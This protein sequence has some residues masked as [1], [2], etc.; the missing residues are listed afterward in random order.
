MN[1]ENKN[2]PFENQNWD[3]ETPA[4][5]HEKRFLNKLKVKKSKKQTFWKPLAIACSLVIGLGVL[6][7]IYSNSIINKSTTEVA[8]SPEVQETN[9][10]FSSIINSELATLKQKETPQSKALISDALKQMESLEKDYE[11]LKLEIKKP[12]PVFLLRFSRF[13]GTFF[14]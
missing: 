4:M 10:Y 9:D 1:I 5:G 13:F 7:F 8:F 12:K 6:Y 11:N 2:N 14:Y 3:F